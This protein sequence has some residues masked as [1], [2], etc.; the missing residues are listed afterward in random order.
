MKHWAAFSHFIRNTF[1]KLSADA[2]GWL[3]AIIM[4]CATLPSL[5]ALMTGLSDH[6]PNLDLVLMVWTGL[7]LLFMRAV[8]LKD[9]L[10]IITIG[11]GFMVQAVL[12]AL[13]MF[14]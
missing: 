13:I 1:S 9:M 11:A 6:T 2:L 3:S 14:R 5:I 12:M 8:L 7:I 4:H 10:N